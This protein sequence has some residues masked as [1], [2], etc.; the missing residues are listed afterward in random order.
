MPF[1]LIDKPKDW[2]SHDVVAVMRGRT[3]TKKVGHAGTLDPFATG[4]LI[5]G[6]ERDATKR[7]DEFKGM[8]K[9]YEATLVFGATSTTQDSDGEISSTGA[10]CSSL[11]KEQVG[12]ALTTFLGEQ[13]QVPPMY[14]AKKIDGTRLYELAR[15][16]KE[17]ER[18]PVDITIYS[19]E[20]LSFQAEDERPTAHIRVVCSTGTY[21]RTLCH[22]I[23][24]ALGVGAYCAE[25][26]RTHIG[27]YD[28]SHA[29]GPKDDDIEPARFDIS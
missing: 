4:L 8:N 2:T 26:R 1:Y 21:I 11:T 23:G 28:V 16:G 5:V 3:K 10:D 22:D 6:V 19:I 18:D 15:K 27:T 20:L 14:S 25:L 24:E 9:T 7:L 13:Q 12:E 17:V 29:V